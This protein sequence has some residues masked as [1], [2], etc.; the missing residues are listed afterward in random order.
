[1]LAIA[2]RPVGVK[3]GIVR[4]ARLASVPWR[5]SARSSESL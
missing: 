5:S 2:E 4:D 3:G 1:M